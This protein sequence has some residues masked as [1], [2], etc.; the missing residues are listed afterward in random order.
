MIY[1][2]F[3]L[4]CIF[5][6]RSYVQKH[7]QWNAE[8]KTGQPIPKTSFGFHLCPNFF[9]AI[10]TSHLRR[11]SS[12]WRLRSANG[13]LRSCSG[14]VQFWIDPLFDLVEP[15]VDPIET[16]FGLFVH[17]TSGYENWLVMRSFRITR[18]FELIFQAF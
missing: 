12:K 7:R 9:T 6:F 3:G 8:S 2:N 11:I 18:H 5:K 4:F 14:S 16:L 17:P 13:H 10:R 1:V 15:L